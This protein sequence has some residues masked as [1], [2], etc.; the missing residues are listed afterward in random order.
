M[1]HITDFICAKVDLPQVQAS[2]QVTVVVS[3]ADVPF[4]PQTFALV[5]RGSF[6]GQATCSSSSCPSDC[7]GHGTC[8]AGKCQCDTDYAGIVCS[9]PII[10]VDYSESRALM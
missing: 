7:S 4:G 8:V 5:V 1:G 9:V 2:A 10:S 3:G 6:S